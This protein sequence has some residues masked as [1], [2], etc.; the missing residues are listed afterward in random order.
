MVPFRIPGASFQLL[1]VYYMHRQLQSNCILVV[2]VIGSDSVELND[3][4]KQ[5]IIGELCLEVQDHKVSLIDFV[6]SIVNHDISLLST[7]VSYCHVSSVLIDSLLLGVQRG[8]TL[9]RYSMNHNADVNWYWS[10]SSRQRRSYAIDWYNAGYQHGTIIE[11][12]EYIANFYP[13]HRMCAIACYSLIDKRK[14]Y[15][16][17]L[18]QL[19]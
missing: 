6:A 16:A 3:P 5:C 18:K 17:Q 2:C 13:G 10:V 7:T 19:K 15:K 8:N 11:A 9:C 12:P 4:C 1:T 14:M